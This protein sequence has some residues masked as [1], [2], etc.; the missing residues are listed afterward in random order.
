M[1][2]KINRRGTQ[3]HTDELL[4]MTST[5][6]TVGRPHG[7]MADSKNGISRFFVTGNVV[8]D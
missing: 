8:I 3:M 2:F 7:V 1:D 5:A 4:V 6:S